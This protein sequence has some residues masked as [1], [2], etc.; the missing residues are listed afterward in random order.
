MCSNGG[1]IVL[2]NGHFP[3]NACSSEGNRHGMNVH[4]KK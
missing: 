1:P 4:A 3:T 2:H